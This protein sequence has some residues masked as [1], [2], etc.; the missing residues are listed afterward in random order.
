MAITAYYASAV[1]LLS[2]PKSNLLL[3]Q[4]GAVVS[5]FSRQCCVHHGPEKRVPPVLESGP[6]LQS[7]MVRDLRK[8][9]T[10]LFLHWA[11][12]NK[13]IWSPSHIF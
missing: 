9:S 5:S 13:R 2:R 12:I 6:L 7:F 3:H 4:A 8:L 1:V 10:L 11:D